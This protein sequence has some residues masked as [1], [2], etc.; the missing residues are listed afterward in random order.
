MSR[1]HASLAFKVKALL[2]AALTLAVPILGASCGPTTTN[3]AGET[4]IA[5]TPEH[6]LTAALKG[7][8]FEGATALAVSPGGGQFRLIHPN[9]ALTLRGRYSSDGNI[10][11]VNEFVI[12]REANLTTLTIDANKRITT[13]SGNGLTWQRP[14]NWTSKADP[15]APTSTEAL[16]AANA[17]LIQ[18][19]N[20]SGQIGATSGS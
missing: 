14:A 4:L 2:C 6:P 7:S 20:E 5:L 19:A 3:T 17:E 12:G 11:A 18:A 15:S 16:L 10:A 13:I 9:A 1:T 8:I